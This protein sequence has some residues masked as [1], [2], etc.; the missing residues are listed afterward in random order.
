MRGQCGFPLPATPFLDTKNSFKKKKK[1]GTFSRIFHNGKVKGGESTDPTTEVNPVRCTVL[2]QFCHRAV[3]KQ[4]CVAVTNLLL[5]HI[6]PYKVV[7]TSLRTRSPFKISTKDCNLHNMQ[8]SFCGPPPKKTQNKV[9]MKKQ[10]NKQ[11]P[12]QHH[13]N[14]R[15]CNC[16][17]LTSLDPVQLQSQGTTML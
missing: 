16:S 3:Q 1:I 7:Q 15:V 6:P 5:G 11:K 13:V 8:D 14:K 4:N 17:L 12:P 9:Q 10:T 2:L